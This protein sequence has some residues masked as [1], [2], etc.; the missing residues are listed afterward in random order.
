MKCFGEIFK[1]KENLDFFIGTF[2]TYVFEC[3]KDEKALLMMVC[4]I[5]NMLDNVESFF[6][7]AI[8]S[9]FF[10]KIMPFLRNL[11]RDKIS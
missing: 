5:Q 6:L 9:K 8:K 1:I 7:Q 4:E 2:F 3:C 11:G 10:I